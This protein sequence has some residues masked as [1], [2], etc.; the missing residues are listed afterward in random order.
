MENEQHMSRHEG[1]RDNVLL[2]I[3]SIARRLR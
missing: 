3:Q 1:I 2:F